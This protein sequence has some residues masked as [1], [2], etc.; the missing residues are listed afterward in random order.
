MRTRDRL[1]VLQNNRL[2]SSLGLQPQD[3]NDWINV[4]A[5]W[6][7]LH[8][9]AKFADLTYRW[10]CPDPGLILFRDETRK[11]TSFRAIS[12]DEFLTTIRVVATCEHGFSYSSRPVWVKMTPQFDRP[13][14][15]DA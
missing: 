2:L 5:D 9:P 14:N 1:I 3:M 6:P 11:H 7:D 10:E 12:A 15:S 8:D 13:D 4:S